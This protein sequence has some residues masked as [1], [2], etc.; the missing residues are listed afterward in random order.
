LSKT[1]GNVVRPCCNGEGRWRSGRCRENGTVGEEE[2]WVAVHFTVVVYDP[3]ISANS[4][5]GPTPGVKSEW[6][7]DSPGFQA[8]LD[9]QRPE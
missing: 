7:R 8:A 5:T 4:N 6:L 9:L 2:A 3:A 1:I